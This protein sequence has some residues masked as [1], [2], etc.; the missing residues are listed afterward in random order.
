MPMHTCIFTWSFSHAQKHIHAHIL[1]HSD[2][3]N[4]VYSHDNT[5]TSLYRISHWLSDT[6]PPTKIYFVYAYVICYYVLTFVKLRII[7]SI[8]VY[9][10][11]VM[12][13]QRFEPCGRR[14]TNV[15]YSYYVLRFH[16]THPLSTIHIFF[17]RMYCAY[18]P[19][20]PSPTDTYF[21]CVCT[22]LIKE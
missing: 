2:T 10:M 14:F 5:Q 22:V 4:D 8:S 7:F 19:P 1:T 13:V 21:M 3:Q 9:I 16:S 12:F 18:I 15:R 6:H 20:T 11:C 17:V